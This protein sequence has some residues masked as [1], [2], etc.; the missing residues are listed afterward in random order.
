MADPEDA[1]ATTKAADEAD[2]AVAIEKYLDQ[3]HKLW[4]TAAIGKVRSAI[5][6]VNATDG[7]FTAE[8]QEVLENLVKALKDED[9]HPHPHGFV[10][11][12]RF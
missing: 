4:V 3:R 7:V 9:P 12:F 11:E 8:Q 5:A 10:S 1:A 6:A 2:E